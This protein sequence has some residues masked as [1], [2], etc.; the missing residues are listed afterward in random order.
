MHNRNILSYL[1]SRRDDMF[2]AA[3]QYKYAVRTELK[4]VSATFFYKHCV[5]TGLRKGPK[6]LFNLHYNALTFVIKFAG[7]VEN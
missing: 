4:S 5:P 1:Q 3:H 6:Y 2:I 7:K